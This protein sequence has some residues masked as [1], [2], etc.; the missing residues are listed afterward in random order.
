MEIRHQDY[1]CNNYIKRFNY[2]KL[3]MRINVDIAAFDFSGSGNSD[4]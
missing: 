3:L 1:V 2:I 4:G